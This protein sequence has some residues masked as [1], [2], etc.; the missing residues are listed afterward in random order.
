[1]PGPS[2]SG[3]ASCRNTGR[4]TALKIQFHP[5]IDLLLRRPFPAQSIAIMGTAKRWQQARTADVVAEC[6]AGKTLISLGAVHEHS[7]G[8]PYTALA[9]VPPHLVEE[10]AREAFLTI[11]GIRVFLIDDVRNGA[12]EKAP[13]GVNELH[14]K[15]GAIVR[16]GLHITLGDLRLKKQFA[17]ARERWKA[18]CC[19]PALFIVGR[20]SA[21]DTARLSR[22]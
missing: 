17:N 1:M 5:R 8:R 9:M 16:E 12:D 3:N 11:P 18:L 7:E 4:S 22:R 10:W 14:L 6:R 2:N 15:R 21:S 13:H 20:E 19:R